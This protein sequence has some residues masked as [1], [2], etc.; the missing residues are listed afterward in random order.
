MSNLT[1]GSLV[2]NSTYY[3]YVVNSTGQYGILSTL[4]FENFVS[5]HW[6]TYVLTSGTANAAGGWTGTFPAFAA[7]F[8]TIRIKLQ[9]GGSPA[10]GDVDMGS[11]QVYWDGTALWNAVNVVFVNGQPA[12]TVPG[13]NT[14][15]AQAGGNNTITLA[16]TD[17]GV[18]GVYIGQTI[19]LIGGT[20]KGQIGTVTAN[21]G[22]TKVV[23]VQTGYT[24]NNWLI[25]PDSTT[26]YMFPGFVPMVTNEIVVN[27]VDVQVS[28]S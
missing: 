18:T 15:I 17:G 16:A 27:Q 9:A 22:T 12:G 14:G 7:G 25:N 28:Q 10:V 26:T 11:Q 4:L 2:P 3:A 19:L 21:N 8:Y 6:S 20:G 23:T 13:V 1:A 24:A 5:G